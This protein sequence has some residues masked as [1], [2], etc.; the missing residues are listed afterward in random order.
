MF[1][2]V[3]KYYYCEKDYG[4]I[5]HMNDGKTMNLAKQGNVYILLFN[6]NEIVV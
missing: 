1:P 3:C 2:L 6:K 5:C 4:N